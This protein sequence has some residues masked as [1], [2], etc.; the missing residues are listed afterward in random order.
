MTEQRPT[1][2]KIAPTIE[3][4]IEEG[5]TE[6]GLPREAVDIEVLDEGTKG[7][8]GLGSREA[9]V[10]LTIKET[11]Q[12]SSEVVTTDQQKSHPQESAIS[13]TA[14]EE[15]EAPAEAS[16]TED[17]DLQVARETVVELLEKMK[18]NAEVS[19][20]YV[21]DD[22]YGGRKPILVNIHGDDLSILIGRK[23]E[24]LNALQYIT[25]LIVGK[26]LS[27]SVPLTVD[28]EGYRTRR[29]KQLKQLANRIADQVVETGRSQALEPMPA[30]ERRIIHI[31]L[32]DH[33]DIYTESTGEGDRR[34]VV[35][36][37]KS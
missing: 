10:L 20:S 34:K 1:I 32:R 21:E 22:D 7:L 28:V 35:I 8:F 17:E 18:I 37:L 13:E 31:A 27:R 6:L 4:A 23:A 2:E 11:S 24:T 30:S 12:P 19:A 9:R 36:Y 15:S 14:P 3:E 16:S 5:L 29:Q 33:P 26:E 25:S